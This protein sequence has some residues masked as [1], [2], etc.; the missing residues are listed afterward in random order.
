MIMSVNQ[1]VAIRR[2]SKTSVSKAWFQA[3]EPNFQVK[4]SSGIH[5][6]QINLQE[7]EARAVQTDQSPVL[8][9]TVI[10]WD[11]F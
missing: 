8:S 1:A 6:H 2:G 7:P 4:R 3:E 11:R 10:E 9:P 5:V